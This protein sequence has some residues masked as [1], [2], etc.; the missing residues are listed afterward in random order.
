[1]PGG[2]GKVSVRGK[3]EM[4]CFGQGCNHVCNVCV[5]VCVGVVRGCGGVC[6]AGARVSYANTLKFAQSARLLR[7]RL[8]GAGAGCW[9]LAAGGWRLAGGWGAVCG[10]CLEV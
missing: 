5:C 2:R 4:F 3:I 10:V 1:M 9:R 7:L 6:G 8:A